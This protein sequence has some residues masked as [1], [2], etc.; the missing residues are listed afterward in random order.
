MGIFGD[1]KLQ[2]ERIAALEDH[3]R[4][5]TDT[6]QA[7]QVDLVEGWVAIL[8][9]KAQ[10]DEKVSAADVDPVIV[11]LNDELGEAREQLEK[12]SAAA[13]E[14]WATVQEG[15]RDALDTLRASMRQAADRIKES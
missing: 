13:S 8:A 1:D 15:A 3:V 10:V 12:A 9:L 5:L 11:K 14:S 4:V 7:N 2:D 6:V